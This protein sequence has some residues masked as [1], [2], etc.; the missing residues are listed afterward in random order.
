MQALIN[1]QTHPTA[2]HAQVPL[3]ALRKRLPLRVLSPADWAHWQA[4]GYVVVHRAVPRASAAR[5]LDELWRFQDLDPA[6]PATWDQPERRP[7]VLPE[8]NNTGMVEIY[9]HP[10]LWAH[11][12]SPRIY[13]A[14]VDIWDT[15]ALWVTIDRANLNTP[16]RGARAVSGDGFI[17][18][19]VDTTLKPLPVGVQGVL[20]LTDQRLTEQHGDVGGF[21]CVPELFHHFDRWLATQPADRDPLHPDMAGLEARGVDLEAGDLLIFNSLLAHGIRPNRSFDGVR[22][23]Q[24]LAMSPADEDDEAERTRR[25]DSWQRREPPKRIAFPGDPRGREQQLPRAALTPLGERLLGLQRWPRAGEEQG[26][27]CR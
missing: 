23:A 3:H 20:S 10:L 7:H 8:I 19:D 14:F 12:Q 15:E 27:P 25:L 18:W 16:N 4:W 17:H 22:A 5:L 2:R 26:T 24:Y 13:D 21:Q 11:R 6:D 9:H 1:E